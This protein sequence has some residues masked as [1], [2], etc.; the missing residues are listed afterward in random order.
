VDIWTLVLRL[1]HVGLGVFWAG[2]M[3]FATFFLMPSLAEAGPD[4]AKVMAGLQRRRLLDVLPVVALITI[5]TGFW[6][7]F[8][9]AAQSPEWARSSTGMALG[10][11]GASAVLALL[12]GLT[13]MRPAQN[14][15]GQLAARMASLPEGPDRAAVGLELSPLRRRIAGTSKVIAGLLIVSV[16]T[17]AVARYL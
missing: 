1:L 7:Y 9:I 10:I 16:I 2:A 6:M 12:L 17:M 5:A 4:G 3:L 11:G 14:R 13:I 8:R 15:V